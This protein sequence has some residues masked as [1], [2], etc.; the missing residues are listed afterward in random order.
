MA[1]RAGGASLEAMND[2]VPVTSRKTVARVAG[3]LYL[4]ASVCFF[5]AMVVRSGIRVGDSPAALADGIRSSAVLFRAGLVADLV[6]WTLFLLTAIALY[7][8]LRHVHRLAAAAM[9]VLVAIMVTVGYVNDVNLFAELTIATDPGYARAFGADGS[10][11]LVRLFSDIHG[12]G[13]VI[14]ELFFGIWLVPLAYLVTRSRQLPRLVGVLLY[15]AAADWTVQFLA[16]VLAPDLPYV[17]EVA[18]VGA[19]GELVFVGWL[20]IVGVGPVRGVPT[21][22]AAASRPS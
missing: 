12:D 6:S 21:V 22:A 4:L 7:A 11:A 1:A 19:V 16:N 2:A 20:L 10:A 8:L 3:S 5:L 13:I 17:F 15:V 9:V 14:D 18:Q